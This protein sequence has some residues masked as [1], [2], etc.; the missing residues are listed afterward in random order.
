MKDNRT[1][2]WQKYA[3]ILLGKWYFIVAGLLIGFSVGY[4][5]N[6]YAVDIY[7]ISAQLIMKKG[8]DDNS[9]STGKRGGL[10]FKRN[11]D[12]RREIAS[13]LSE[14]NLLS[15]IQKV[16]FSVSYFISGDVRTTE[17][18]PEKP[19]DVHYDT[20]SAT[21][22]FGTFFTLEGDGQKY[23]IVSEDEYWKSQLSSNYVPWGSAFLLGSVPVKITPRKEFVLGSGVKYSF[24]L[25]DL[26]S[27][28]LSYK[29]RILIHWADPSSSLVDIS[30]QSVIPQKDLVF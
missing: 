11:K 2:E 4:I 3:F 9:L 1:P 10:R 29:D 8:D 16:D 24:V 14:E 5:K 13:L 7:S 30:C 23:R 15:A 25:N 21:N 27:V 26:R 28:A 18:Y 12:T 22:P 17:I 20:L 6:R 19:F